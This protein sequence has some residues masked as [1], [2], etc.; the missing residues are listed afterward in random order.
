M[1]C[2]YI[3]CDDETVQLATLLPLALAYTQAREI[4]VCTKYQQD[5][6]TFIEKICMYITVSYS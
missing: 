6:D 3:T 1:M 2:V 4:Y 5:G